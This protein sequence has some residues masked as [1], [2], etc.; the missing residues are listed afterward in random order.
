MLLMYYDNGDGERVY[1]LKVSFSIKTVLKRQL[2]SNVFLVMV[3]VLVECLEI[4]SRYFSP[5][6]TGYNF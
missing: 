3:I 4:K 2:L 5:R 1:T 6:G